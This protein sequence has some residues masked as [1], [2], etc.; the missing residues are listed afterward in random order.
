MCFRTVWPGQHWYCSSVL[1]RAN[2]DSRRRPTASS[3]TS[4]TSD[5]GSMTVAQSCAR[6]HWCAMSQATFRVRL[7][8]ASTIP[9]AMPVKRQLCSCRTMHI[10][11][12]GISRWQPSVILSAAQ[13]IADVPRIAIFIIRRQWWISLSTVRRLFDDSCNRQCSATLM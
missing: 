3:T 5:N 12:A 11:V 10:S 2:A 6:M 1:L 13:S 4:T 8:H 9:L 7:R